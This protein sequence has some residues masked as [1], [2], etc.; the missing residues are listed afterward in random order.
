MLFGTPLLLL[1]DYSFIEAVI[2]LLPISISI[3]IIQIAKDYRNVDLEF[4]KKI[5]FFTIPF[6]VIFLF[7]VS[8]VSINIGLI[9]GSFLL[10][11]A[12]KDYSIN[13]NNSDNNHDHVCCQI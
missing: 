6:V 7:V 12:A 1:R 5:L 3:N 13:V 8:K 4:Y 10:V 9:I 11:V 2:I